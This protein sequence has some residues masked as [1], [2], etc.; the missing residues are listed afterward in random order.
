LKT[1]EETGAGPALTGARIRARRL[2]RGMQQ[3]DL[4]LYSAKNA[5]RGTHRFYR[6][7]M[8]QDGGDLFPRDPTP[9]RRTGTA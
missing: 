4:A 8:Q 3:A 5:G 1:R 7:D 6:P 2:D 9:E